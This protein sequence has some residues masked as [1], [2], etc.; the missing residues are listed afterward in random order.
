MSGLAGRFFSGRSS[1]TERERDSLVRSFVGPNVAPLS[2]ADRDA[3]LFVAGRFAP[4]G[5][6]SS[7]GEILETDRHVVAL[8][9]YIVNLADLAGS[10]VRAPGRSRGGI[11]LQLFERHGPAVLDALNGGYTLI[12]WDTLDRVATIVTCK[13]GQRNLYRTATGVGT[14]FATDLHALRRISGKGFELDRDTACMSF[15]YGGVYGSPTALSG[16]ARVLPGSTLV[17]RATSV[18]ERLASDLPRGSS[19]STRREKSFYVDRLDAMMC[20]SA[21]R[22]GS[23]AA[24]HAVMLGSGVDSSLVAAYAKGE[25]RDLRAVTQKMPGDADE[26]SEAAAIVKALGIPQTIVPYEPRAGGL[27]EDVAAFV[28]IAEEPAYWNQLGPPLLHLLGSLDERPAAFLTGAEG[29]FLFNFRSGRRPSI[30]RVLRDGLFWPVASHTARRLVNRVTR[31][32]YIVG[33]D[34]DLMDRAFMRQHVALDCTAQAGAGGFIDPGYPHL[35]PGPNAQRHF[36]NNGWQNV[37][38]ISQFGRDAGVEVLFPYLDDDVVACILS[39]PPELKINKGLLRILLSRFLP[40]GVIPRRKKG[41]W[42]HTV[43]WHYEQGGLDAVLGV[44]SERRTVDRG[45]YDPRALRALVEAYASGQATPRSH[46]VLWQ[47]LVFEMF[48]REFVDGPDHRS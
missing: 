26:S 46:P 8:E 47:L 19:A 20:Q 42:A 4:A 17:L 31:R 34:F 44:M 27:L 41:Y 21:S 43:R 40:H 15:L 7:Y 14:S 1:Y 10:S 24:S 48:C 9:G 6:S 39:L 5:I 28:R 18:T 25:T 23:V 36:I 29:D 16:V 33:S 12:I 37:R 11:I 3:A 38:I 30:T 13:F 32:S 45:V 22:L 35:A 2:Y